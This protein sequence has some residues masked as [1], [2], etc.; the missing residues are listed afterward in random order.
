[1]IFNK[2]NDKFFVIINLFLL[3]DLACLKSLLH[4]EK[5][6]TSDHVMHMRARMLKIA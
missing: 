4:F 3:T 1:M 6:K 5:Q 2:N